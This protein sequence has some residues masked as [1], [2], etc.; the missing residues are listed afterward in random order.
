MLSLSRKHPSLG[1]APTWM[2]DD[3]AVE[4]GMWTMPQQA[5]THRKVYWQRLVEHRWGQ[6]G[7]PGSKCALEMERAAAAILCGVTS[8]SPASITT[9]QGRLSVMYDKP[10]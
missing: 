3:D 7:L 5:L 9:G 2:L 8:L 6:D 4:A 1:Q 10:L